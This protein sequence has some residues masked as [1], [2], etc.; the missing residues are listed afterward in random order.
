MRLRPNLLAFGCALAFVASVAVVLYVNFQ[1]N[2][3]FQH[4]EIGLIAALWVAVFFLPPFVVGLRV[5][6]YGA[7]Y[8]LVVGLVPLVIAFLI[9][10]SVPLFFAAFFY[11][12]APLGGFLGQRF[13]RSPSAG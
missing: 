2:P 1:P 4:R 13:S 10:Y 7:I 11:A 8:G 12:L 9:G 5:N 3:E 6:E